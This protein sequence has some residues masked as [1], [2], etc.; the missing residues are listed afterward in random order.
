MKMRSLD[1]NFKKGLGI[2]TLCLT[3]LALEINE[4]AREKTTK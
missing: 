1:I 3:S 4:G 2:D